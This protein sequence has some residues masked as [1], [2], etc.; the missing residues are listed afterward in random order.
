[1]NKNI[2]IGA[3]VVAV[4]A[5]VGFQFGLAGPGEAAMEP[6]E[7]TGVEG[8]EALVELAQGV[9]LGNAD[10]PITIVEFG[11]YQ[12][13]GCMMFNQGVKPQVELSLIESGEAKFVFYDFPLTNIHPW[14]F[15]A[16][17][18]GRCA[19]GQG[20]FWDF[21]DKVFEYQQ[22][23]SASATAPI[24]DFVGYAG[25]VGLDAGAFEACLR[26]DQY[27]DVVTANMNLAQQLGVGST[28]TVMISVNGSPAR[29][30]SDNSFL[31][32]QSTIEALRNEQI[33]AGSG[34]GEG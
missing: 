20:N 30:A 14:A 28:P 2:I 1:M 8:A 4:V 16:A 33:V 25:D 11:D 6:I 15:L 31:G 32:I 24:G 29:Q 3:V 26:S 9:T 13:P 34:G 19:E 10:A 18:A 21:H 12:C 5:V 17:R 7:L 27:A 23:W 22:R